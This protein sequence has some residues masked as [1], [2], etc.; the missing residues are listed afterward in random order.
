MKF[1]SDVW[2]FYGFLLLINVSILTSSYLQ[3]EKYK[4]HVKFENST[5]V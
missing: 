3:L 1:H 5:L 2:S 4:F